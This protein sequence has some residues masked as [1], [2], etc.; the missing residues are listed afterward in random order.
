MVTPSLRQP[1]VAGRSVIWSGT[2]QLAW[3]GW[4][5][6]AGGPLELSPAYANTD[7]LNAGELT[8]D[9]LPDG[10]VFAHAAMQDRTATALLEFRE[11]MGPDPR[12]T[13]LKRAAE[14]E[15]ALEGPVA[16]AYL[17]REITLPAG[18]ARLPEPLEFE[19]QKV[20]AFGLAVD[21]TGPDSL[22]LARVLDYSGPE[23]FVVEMSTPSPGEQLILARVRP[24]LTLGATIDAVVQRADAASAPAPVGELRVPFMNYEIEARFAEIEGHRIAGPAGEFP[25]VIFAA[26]AVRFRLDGTGGGARATADARTDADAAGAAPSCIFN[27]PFLMLLRRGDAPPYFA[28]WVDNAELM[29]G[30]E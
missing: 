9:D 30:A 4:M 24:E 6:A 21:E 3:N 18:Y 10:S 13:T 5:E 7:V 25:R 22:P 17:R 8:R 23:D 19:G 20:H 14:D 16:Y 28:V 27:G 29:H 1:I 26:Q 11:A 2:F 15:P 12:A